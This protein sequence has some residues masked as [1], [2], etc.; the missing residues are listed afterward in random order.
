MPLTASSSGGRH[1]VVSGCMFI[2]FEQLGTA[3]MSVWVFS[4]AQHPFIEASRTF[5]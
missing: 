5:V 2:V 4:I 3:T 1:V